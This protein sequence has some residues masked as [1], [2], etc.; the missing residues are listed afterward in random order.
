[1]RERVADFDLEAKVLE[2]SLVR[3]SDIIVRCQFEGVPP[4]FVFT[5]ST[6]ASLATI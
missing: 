1:M 6:S 4:S 5:L 2:T 3:M